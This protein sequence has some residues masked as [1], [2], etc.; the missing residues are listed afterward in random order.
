M[1]F[2]LLLAVLAVNFCLCMFLLGL[3]N[4]L[5]FAPSLLVP[6]FFNYKGVVF[7]SSYCGC[8]GN[9]SLINCYLG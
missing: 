3:E 1:S 6:K 8:F 7:F 2:D 5:T 9:F 4:I